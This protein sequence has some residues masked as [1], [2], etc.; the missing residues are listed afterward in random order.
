MNTL[1]EYLS[2]IERTEK[3]N[4]RIGILGEI[5]DEVHP[6]ASEKDKVDKYKRIARLLKINYNDYYELAKVIF[7]TSYLKTTDGHWNYITAVMRNKRRG[8]LRNGR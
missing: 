3:R 8:N 4:D 6:N 5:F 1:S 2:R 7:E